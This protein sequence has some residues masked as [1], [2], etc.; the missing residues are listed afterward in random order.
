MPQKL[1]AMTIVL[2]ILTFFLLASLWG[3][4]TSIRP[5]KIVSTITPADLGLDFEHVSFK[6][7][8]GITLAGWF[9]PAQAEQARTV[10][11]LHG[12]PADKGDILPALSFLNKDYNLFLFDFRHLGQSEG[13]YSTAGAR[14]TA[15]LLA[16]ISYLKSRDIDE[17]GVWGFSMGGAVALMTAPQSPEIRA[18]VSEASYARLDLMVPELYRVP[19]LRYPLGWLTELWAK[20]F[21]NINMRNISPMASARELTIPV[22]LVHSKNDNVIPFENALLLQDALKNNGRAEFW[23]E[24]DLSHGQLGEQYQQKIEDFFKRNL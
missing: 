19:I 4:Y 6:A 22:L 11:L 2:P 21:L 7:A 12:Y 17:V 9:I 23:F 14:E 15:D 20:L 18:I 16:A 5:P 1:N 24:D 3:F 10:I 8:D 13:A